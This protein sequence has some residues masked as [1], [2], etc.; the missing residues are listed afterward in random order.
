[1]QSDI[2]IFLSLG[3]IINLALRSPADTRIPAQ[4]R[5]SLVPEKVSDSCYIHM[6]YNVFFHC[7]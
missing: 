4:C 7:L 1:M 2:F 5:L 6:I 3:K